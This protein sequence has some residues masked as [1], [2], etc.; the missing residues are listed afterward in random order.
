[1]TGLPV[2]VLKKLINQQDVSHIETAD[3][4][5]SMGT[6]AFPSIERCEADICCGQGRVNILIHVKLI[7]F[8]YVILF[9]FSECETS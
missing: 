4:G 2:I 3:V 1:M 5:L 7:D 8:K 6:V 9:H